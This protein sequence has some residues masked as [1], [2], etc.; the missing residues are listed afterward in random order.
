MPPVVSACQPLNRTAGS[1]PGRGGAILVEPVGPFQNEGLL[2]IGKGSTFEVAGDLIE[3]GPQAH[4]AVELGGL[5]PDEGFGRLQVTGAATLAGT[6]EVTLVDGFMLDLGDQFAIVE[7]A[8]LTGQ[9]AK[10][11]DPDLGHLALAPLY[12][13]DRLLLQA[14]YLG[15]ANLDGC[16]DGLDYNSWSGHYRMAGMTWLE[17]DY[18]GD[19]MVDGLD[20]NNWSLNYQSGCDGTR[21]PEPAFAVLLIAGLG[22]VLRRRP[23]G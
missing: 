12:Q 8:S 17:A 22:P 11:L 1:R 6:L 14:A 4:L 15:D 16:V 10:L 7:C 5:I 18:N 3:L 21:I 2:S 13:P 9:F 20:Y 23:N 19:T